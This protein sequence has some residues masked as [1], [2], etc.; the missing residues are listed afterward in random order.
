MQELLEE[1][2]RTRFFAEGGPL[3]GHLTPGDAGSRVAFV[4]GP[5]ASGKSY[6]TDMLGHWMK[7]ETPPVEFIGVSMRQRT[8]EGM[9]RCF[10]YGPLGDKD[11]T[12]SVSTIA[13]KGG[14]R[15]AK[16]RA[17]PCMLQLDEPDLGL[18]EEFGFAMGQWIATEDPTPANE[19][20]RGLVVVTHS[21]ELLR[22]FLEVSALKPHFL[23][24]G[25]PRS[26]TM[27]EWLVRPVSRR[28]MVELQELSGTSIQRY[29]DIKKVLEA[30][31]VEDE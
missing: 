13:L 8:R 3:V 6:V 9:H 15:T 18:A 10:M 4:V 16:E 20:C 27:T 30:V 12:G 31:T 7:A 24:L 22:G 5:N 23:H 14:L 11:S 2:L 26:V 19:K 1:V 25:S 28:S 29:R 17:Y 21:R